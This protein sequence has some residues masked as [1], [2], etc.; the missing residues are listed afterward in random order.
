MALVVAFALGLSANARVNDEIAPAGAVLINRAEATYADDKGI[1]FST[2]SPTI[3]LTVMA[4]AT[5]TVTP[6]ETEPSASVGPQ[7]RVSRLFRICN[8]GNILANYTITQA[9]VTVPATFAALFFGSD[10]SGTPVQVGQTISPNVAPGSCISTLMVI[11]TNDSPP[12]TNLQIHLTARSNANGTANGRGEDTGTIVNAVGAGPRLTDPQDPSLPPSLRVN[13][14]LLLVAG[15]GVPFTYSIPFRNSGD[16]SARAVVLAD[17]LPTGI[18]YVSG[19]LQLN[20]RTLSDAEDGDEGFVRGSHV[21]THIP[22]VKPGETF[23]LTLKARLSAKIVD[24]VGFVN[25]AVLT[26]QNITATRS[27]DAVVMGDPFG[28]VFAGRAGNSVPLAGAR[29]ELFADQTATNLLA[30]P[31]DAGFTPNPQN[32]NPFSTDPQGRFSFALAPQQLGSDTSPAT[33][34]MRVTS[35]GYVTRMLALDVRPSRDGLFILTAR[36]IDGQPLASAGSFNLVR[37][38]VQIADLG[39]VA[40]NIPMFESQGLEITK[41]V[42]RARA[43]IGDTLTYRIQVHNPTAGPIRDTMVRDRLPDSFHYVATTARLSRGTSAQDSIEP[44]TVNG[45][46]LF[47]IGE[48]AHGSTAQLLYRVRV[49]AN[50]HD[51]DQQNVAFAAGQFLSGE[52]TAAGPAIASVKLGSGVFS[53]R[54][55]IVGRV[56]TDMNGNGQFDVGDKPVPDVRLYLNSGQSVITDS[57]GLYNFPSLGD[58]AQVIALDP[59]TVPKGQVLSDGGTYAGRS[60]SRLLRTPVGG[61]ALLRQNFI[62]VAA[63]GEAAGSKSSDK[64]LID[65]EDANSNIHSQP[66]GSKAPQASDSI[67][68]GTERV[69]GSNADAKVVKTS[70]FLPTTAGRYEFAATETIAPVPPGSV[71]VLSPAADSIV[72]TPALEVMARVTLKWT[73]KLEV[74]GEQ[75]SEKNIGTSRLDQKNQVATFTFVSIGLRPGPNLVRLTPISPDGTPGHAEELTVMGRGQARRIE[76]V[77]EKTEIHAGGRDSTIVKILL[78]DQWN[79]PANDNQVAIESSLGQL[80]SMENK[81]STRVPQKSPGNDSALIDRA[82]AQQA[83]GR[84]TQAP[85]QIVLPLNN[86]EASVRLVGPASPGEVQLRAL[87][88]EIDTRAS[89]RV[90]PEIRPTILVGLAEASFGPSVPEIN[91]RGEQGNSRNRLSFFYNGRLWGENILTLSYDTQRPINRTTGHDRLFQLDPLDRVYPLFGDSSTRYEA[92]QSNSKLYAR[93]DHGRSYAMFGDFEADMEGLTL[94]GYTRKLT[95]VKLHAENSQGDFVTITGA[96]PDTAFAR[97][98]FPAGTLSILRLSNGD[99]LQGSENVVL[100]VR[101]RRNPEIILSSEALIRSVDYNLNPLDGELFLLRYISTFDSSLNL[102]QLVVTYE[103][104]AG[105]ISSGIYTGRAQKSFKGL[106]L[107]LGLSTIVHPQSDLGNFFLGGIDGEKTL[108][109]RGN[110]RF[111]W[112]RSRGQFIGGGNAIGSGDSEHDGD[113]YQVDLT[114]PLPFRQAILRARYQRAAAGFF[115]PFGATI[116]PGSRRGEASFEFKPLTK[117]MVKFGLVSERNQTATVNNSRLTLSA[118]WDQV[119]NERLRFHFGYDH[120]SFSDDLN[121][122][123]VGSNLITAAAEI[124]PT[125]K[126]QLSIKREQNLTEADPT[127][128]NQTTLGATYRVNEWVKV[129]LTQR[130]A[131]A[132][133]VPIADVALTGFAATGSRRETA[134]GVETRLGKLTSM[135]GRYQ[136]ENGING[137]DSFAVIGL[138]HR[139]PVSDK[140]SLD[141]GFE[142]GF[143]LAGNGRSFNSATLGFGWQP[144]SDFRASARYEFRDRGGAGQVLTIGAAG[145]IS[146]GIT[147]LS[148]FQISRSSLGGRDS[149]AMDGLASLA[150]R[151]LKSD[152]IGL[153]FSYNHR[154]LSQQSA[155]NVTPTRDRIDS[156]SAD[157]Y[158]Q[159]TKKL[160]LYGRFAFRFNANGQPD[161][162]FVSSLTMLTQAR[163]QYRLTPRI[164]W[165]GEMRTLWQASSGTRR[166]VYASELGFW[167]LP[168]L[169]LGVGYNFNIAVEPAGSR[170][171]PTRRGFYFTISSKL[172]NLFDLFGTSK[173]GLA[174]SSNSQSSEEVKH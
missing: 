154:S 31:S 11:D 6:K 115:N 71:Q 121:N 38:A 21:E 14:L 108:P 93:L 24:G 130:L 80:V 15:P 46:L 135:I 47:A 129:F 142:R 70:F 151:P 34:F 28:V 29:V 146:E 73:A 76:I 12:Q 150:V 5:L 63:S 102:M 125:D 23:N 49:G 1:T 81:D 139:L 66:A 92:A 117:S 174:T 51:G 155:V 13:G 149:S 112:A 98:V 124:N 82:L 138:Q 9:D 16:I 7:E 170:L 163:A 8:T 133:I 105:G 79:H 75:I 69:A 153:L 35:T 147:A 77:P 104:S 61:G 33:Y 19:S 60:W 53:T 162:P 123:S 86:G 118:A 10:E 132:P 17:D 165:A 91:L 85:D 126:L 45:E 41:S 65:R 144:T 113:A 156:I 90:V 103:H 68:A 56:F 145:R 36:A 160:E 97:D 134:I 106:G 111:A 84:S 32:G 136:I 43:E 101:D 107:K 161:L 54:Q 67:P 94:T 168:D 59:T 30:I 89:V 143:H 78:F 88:G 18:D 137:N 157:G 72:M 141:L 152:R 128:P 22:E 127:Y 122:H 99:I 37:E 114:Q 87:S 116:T 148:R 169:R 57:Q 166:S 52:Q 158:Y 83:S 120:R 140:L 131:S 173:E 109:L 74:N 164:D 58:G 110:L 4:V 55:I 39:A 3:T 159:A 172:S 119:V 50:A 27:N 40:F 62:L 167:A 171:M 95:G 26:G 96:R 20:Q 48:I 100:E 25:Y 44:E 2:V 42:D 64:S